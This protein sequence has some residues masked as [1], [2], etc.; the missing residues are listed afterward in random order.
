MKSA[1]A[2]VREMIVSAVG[3]AL[4]GCRH[5]PVPRSGGAP[6]RSERSIS[7]VRSAGPGLSL[8]SFMGTRGLC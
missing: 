4:G 7:N 5:G 1:R 6:L 8:S 3:P 2:S